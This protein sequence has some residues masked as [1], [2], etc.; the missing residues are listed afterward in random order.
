[1]EREGEEEREIKTERG[2]K[3]ESEFI[4]LLLTMAALKGMTGALAHFSYLV[5]LY[6]AWQ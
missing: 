2:R 6:L 5:Q 1:M 3:R 4:V